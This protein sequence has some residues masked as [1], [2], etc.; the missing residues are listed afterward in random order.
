MRPPFRLQYASNL[1]VDR[2]SK[3]FHEVLRPA[4]P[5]LAL[6]GNIG[7]PE[8]PNTHH[9][10]RYCSKHW[11]SVY[12]IPGPHELSNPKE[13]R[14]TF[15]EK[16]RHCASLTK[17]VPRVR[18]LDSN[19]AVYHD[20]A[21]V[22]LG[23]PL[24]THVRLPPKAQPEF[25][26]MYTSVDEAGPIPLCHPVRNQLYKRNQMFLKERSIFWLIV[27]PSVHLV[28]LTHT[29][30]SPLLYKTHL[31][32][33]TFRRIPLDCQVSFTKTANSWLGGAGGMTQTAC[34]G[35]DPRQQTFCGTNGYA[36]YVNQKINPEYDPECVLEIPSKPPFLSL[37]RL[38]L[39]PL[40]SSLTE[41]KV[42]LAYA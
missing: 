22:L 1:F 4:A 34:L 30:P 12:W 3:P 33:E 39:P 25:E 32:E 17:E 18:L 6:L 7:R 5:S 11:K 24:W 2:L 42:S 13:G 21:V 36:E 15:E 41:Q 8:S 27:Q 16:V 9:F 20:H 29:L 28:Y 23:T 14:M 31:S 37:P 26:R 40:F 10:L 35:S 38:I 19:E